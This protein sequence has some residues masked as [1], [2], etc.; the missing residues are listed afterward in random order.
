MSLAT[1]LATLKRK[2]VDLTVTEV[3][4]PDNAADILTLFESNTAA[5]A[6]TANE[7]TVD[8]FPDQLP[9]MMYIMHVASA[10]S[11]KVDHKD[12][13]KSSLATVVM[14]YVTV[15]Q[16]FFLLNDLHV[17]PSPSAHA[18]SWSQTSYKAAFAEWLLSLPVP[19][20]M[21]TILAQLT[22]TETDRTK[23]IFFVPSAAGFHLNHF[24]GRF[25]PINFFAHLHDCIATM[26]GNSKRQDIEQ[27]FFTRKLF[28][29]PTATKTFTTCADILGI[30]TDGT[31]AKYPSGK[32]YQMFT[33]IFNPVLFRDFHR[34]SSLAT[35]DLTLPKLADTSVNAYDILL[36]ASPHNLK[37][38]KVVLQHVSAVLKGTVP[39]SKTL[40]QVISEGSGSNILHHGYSQYPLPSWSANN[41][42]ANVTFLSGTGKT[43]AEPT[44]DRASSFGFLQKPSTG[45]TYR[46]TTKQSVSVATAT[47]TDPAGARLQSVT[48]PWSLITASADTNAS[49]KDDAFITF[50]DEI[51]VTP[52]VHVLDT[53]GTSTIS[54]HLATLA[55]KIIQTL[56]LDGTT[57]EL[58]HPTK[59]LAAQNSLFAD[60]AIPLSYVV[61]ATRFHV[62]TDLLPPAL[63]R[64]KY[65]ATT[66]QPASSILHDRTKINLPH[67]GQHGTT[68]GTAE[69]YDSQTF[70]YL[71]GFTNFGPTN[72][73]KYAQSFLGFQ[74]RSPT[75]ATTADTVFAMEKGRLYVWSPYTYTSLEDNDGQD[76][77]PD[78]LQNHTYF[79]TNLRTL[80]GT[81]YNLVECVH[82]FEAMPV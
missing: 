34:R 17:R 38:L 10:A 73:L 79:L 53:L 13:S 18:A 52:K 58:P 11:A 57:I 51:H 39:T 9:I 5:K 55:G 40:S 36:S 70:T 65:K 80:F 4:T 33:S 20:S 35:L 76:M 66:S 12:N 82:P 16:A 72:W 81:D 69:I 68:T 2:T 46:P 60:S 27:D 25:V 24:F 56:E 32:W 15:L 21:L 3:K 19:D 41:D 37:E 44:A 78:L 49:P 1:K 75:S 42:N 47:A 7:W 59:S 6:A 64:H 45:R 22:A 71:P 14:Y 62:R 77:L 54:A 26:P 8:V 50:D 61:F 23:N 43:T 74:T 30:T 29:V 67:L 48:Y 28:S 63:P 31:N